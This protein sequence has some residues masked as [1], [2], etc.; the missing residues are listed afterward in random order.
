MLRTI[1]NR[2]IPDPAY[3]VHI[4]VHVVLSY[5]II[6]NL[7][8]DSMRRQ[9]EAI[10]LAS[11][12]LDT[13]EPPRISLDIPITKISLDANRVLGVATPTTGARPGQGR[14]IELAI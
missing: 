11:M 14:E 10:R 2:L 3:R 6:L 1:R 5:R 12:M 9:E 13:A 8:R 4:T 7:C